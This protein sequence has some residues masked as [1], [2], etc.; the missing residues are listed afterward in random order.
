MALKKY[1]ICAN[2]MIEKGFT[3]ADLTMEM[4][5]IDPTA[6]KDLLQKSDVIFNF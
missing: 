5:L 3:A 1:N 4:I 2:S 6:I